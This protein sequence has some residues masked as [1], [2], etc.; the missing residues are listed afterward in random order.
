MLKKLLHVVLNFQTFH[1]RRTRT[2]VCYKFSAHKQLTNEHFKLSHCGNV[3]LNSKLYFVSTKCQKGPSRW[4]HG[5]RHGSAVAHF[6]G[7]QVWIL[8]GACM[9]CLLWVL[10][11]IRLSSLWQADHLSRGVQLGVVCVRHKLH[12]V[13]LHATHQLMSERQVN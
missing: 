3:K 9:S 2:F 7:L 12:K 10:Y 11:A 1:F 8:P 4:S 5:L 13:I 6:M